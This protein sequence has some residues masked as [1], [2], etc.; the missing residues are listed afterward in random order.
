M[1]LDTIWRTTKWDKPNPL[2][3]TDR[4]NFVRLQRYQF[5]LQIKTANT[6]C[7]FRTLTRYRE[8]LHNINF[9]DQKKIAN[10]GT[11]KYRQL[12]PL[13][14][15]CFRTQ[16]FRFFIPIYHAIL[17][18]HRRST[19]I[20]RGQ[21]C[22]PSVLQKIRHIFPVTVPKTSAFVPVCRAAWFLAKGSSDS[23]L[24]RHA[25]LVNARN[26]CVDCAREDLYFGG[27]PLKTL[28]SCILYESLTEWLK[29]K[30]R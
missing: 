2:F 15:F 19:K 25:I 26:G 28:D 12:S 9:G 1:N 3:R 8:Y 30:R 27:L 24:F 29:I 13:L 23:D 4:N 20:R 11:S 7:C 10:R 5:E 14:S 21:G 18:V 17:V 22:P 16:P 6:L